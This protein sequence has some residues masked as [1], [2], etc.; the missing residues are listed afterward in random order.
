L[1]EC[2]RASKFAKYEQILK[3]SVASRRPLARGYSDERLG[4][5]GEGGRIGEALVV[6]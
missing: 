1:I 5:G 4:G 2:D 6:E 3:N